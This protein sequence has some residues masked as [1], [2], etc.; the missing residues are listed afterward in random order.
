MN[1][2]STEGYDSTLNQAIERFKKQMEFSGGKL[3]LDGNG[4]I[5][6]CKWSNVPEVQN[7]Q[8][9]DSSRREDS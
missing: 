9:S 6:R 5:T 3:T 1:S 8:V 7:G 4:K 2:I